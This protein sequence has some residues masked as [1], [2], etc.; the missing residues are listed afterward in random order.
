LLL[1]SRLKTFLDC[2]C[3]HA[4]KHLWNAAAI[5]PQIISELPLLLLQSHPQIISEYRASNHLKV[6]AAIAHQI[7]SELLLQSRL[8]SSLNRCCNRSSNRL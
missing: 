2:Y 6:A 1:Q 4:S 7:V 5:T 3:N 8:K